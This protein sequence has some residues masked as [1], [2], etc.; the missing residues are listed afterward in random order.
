MRQARVRL[1]HAD[2]TVV[3]Q[4]PRLSPHKKAMQESLCRLL[5]LGPEHVNVKATTE[6]GLGFTGDLSGIKAYATVC[7]LKSETI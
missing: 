5:G 6:E 2:V 4:K 3:A 1:T 7:G